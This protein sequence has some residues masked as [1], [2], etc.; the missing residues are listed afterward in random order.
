PAHAADPLGRG[1]LRADVRSGADGEREVADGR[2]EREEDDR[3]ARKEWFEFARHLETGLPRHRV[4]EKDQVR[5]ELERFLD[6]VSS[7]DGLADDDEDT[8]RREER[9]DH[10]SDREVA[11]DDEYAGRQSLPCPPSGP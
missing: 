3:C 5:L 1:R 10:L 8:L 6:T 11:A 4:V 7:I 2:V 9:A